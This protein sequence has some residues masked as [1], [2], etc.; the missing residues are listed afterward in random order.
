MKVLETPALKPVKILQD[1][2]YIFMPVCNSNKLIG[3]T[4]EQWQTINDKCIEL[5]NAYGILP[6]P[7]RLMMQ[8]YLD[9]EESFWSACYTMHEI[10]PG[11]YDRQEICNLNI[12]RQVAM[13]CIGTTGIELDAEIIYHSSKFAGWKESD[14]FDL[15]NIGD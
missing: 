1:A 10:I 14:I 4:A 15:K 7:E 9:G 6:E 11:E 12:F 5:G 3:L 2:G 8:V 13:S